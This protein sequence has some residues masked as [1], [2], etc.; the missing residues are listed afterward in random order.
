MRRKRNG[1]VRHSVYT[2]SGMFI[3]R[4]KPAHGGKGLVTQ[5]REQRIISEPRKK[6]QAK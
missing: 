1:K 4:I 2:E 6:T 3:R 5:R